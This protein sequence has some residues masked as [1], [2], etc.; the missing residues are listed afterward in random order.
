[1]PLAPITKP[2]LDE[3]LAQL[4]LQTGRSDDGDVVAAFENVEV[5]FIL[6]EAV[7][8]VR[9]YWLGIVTGE[10][11]QDRLREV[12]NAFNSEIPL[13]KVSRV[14]A[15][16]GMSVEFRHHFLNA[17]GVSDEQ[18]HQMLDL[19]FQVAFYIIEGVE[20]AFPDVYV[21]GEE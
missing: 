1:M 14:M 10:G 7:T 6:D 18:L 5:F 15:P 13:G 8:T 4:G 3:A 11:E 19:F 12:V 2:R 16:G 9:A 21:G 17:T 20:A